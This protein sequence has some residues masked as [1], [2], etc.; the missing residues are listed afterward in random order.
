VGDGRA[1]EF[2]QIVDGECIGLV[3]RR[4]T[5]SSAEI[6]LPTRK[7]LQDARVPSDGVNGDLQPSPST[8]S[9]KTNN[10]TFPPQPLPYAPPS[11]SSSPSSVASKAATN[12]LNR[13]LSIA[14]KK[15]FGNG[16]SRSSPSR[17][18]ASLPASPRRPQVITLEADA[19]RD[20]LEDDLL[21][22]LE[23]LAQKTDVLTH[24]ADEMYEYVKAIPQSL[25]LFI[26]F[27]SW[28]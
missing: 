11:L 12:A 15:L 22:M 10:I 7:P 13:A 17:E 2:N 3:S 8:D 21:A 9:A 26:F 4:E 6:K 23:D 24:W 14:S 27:A 28:C 1:V 20:P 25:S 16:S 19:E 5:N 18:N